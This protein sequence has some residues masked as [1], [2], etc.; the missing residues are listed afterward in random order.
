MLQARLA[1]V[2]LERALGALRAAAAR[3]EVGPDDRVVLFVTGDGL[4]TLAPVGDR[5]RPVE[6]E[7]DADAVLEALR[8]T[9]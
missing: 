3:G 1:N 7:P 8:V 2:R 6:I 5:L 4:K 9:V